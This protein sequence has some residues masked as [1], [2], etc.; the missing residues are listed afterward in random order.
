MNTPI[1]QDT[2]PIKQPVTY[3]AEDIPAEVIL[4]NNGNTV[5]AWHNICPHQGRPLNYA[6]N[7]FL[8]TPEGLL[9]CAAH[10]ATFD[11]QSGECVNG[12][13]KGASLKPISVEVNDDGVLIF[14]PPTTQDDTDNG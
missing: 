11:M 8:V 2:L 10:G 7:K 9:M 4:I 13:C 6:P 3:I 14:Q 1:T 12:P 5:K